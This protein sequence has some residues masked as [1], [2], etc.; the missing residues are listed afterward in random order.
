MSLCGGALLQMYLWLDTDRG[1]EFRR[2]VPVAL[3]EPPWNNDEAL[4]NNISVC[5]PLLYRVVR[6]HRHFHRATLCHRGH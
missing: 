2:Q 5:A 4:A 1:M 6:I 3:S